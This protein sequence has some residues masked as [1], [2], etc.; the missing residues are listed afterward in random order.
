MTLSDAEGGILIS[1]DVRDLSELDTLVLATH[2]IDGIAGYKLGISLALSCGLTEAVRR[3]RAVCSLPIV[4]D[5]QKGATDIPAMGALF[6]R[7]CASAGVHAA[8]LFPLSGPATERAWIKELRT[9]GVEPV[10]GGLMTHPGFLESE[11]G[12]LL[13]DAPRRMIAAAREEGVTSFVVPGT[14][15]ELASALAAGLG[16]DARFLVPGIG[17]QGGTI[18]ALARQL[19]IR[20]CYPIIGSAVYNSPSPRGSAEKFGESY[21]KALEE[22]QPWVS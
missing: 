17:T 19:P 22:G 18:D 7:V 1:C 3:V 4:Y 6:A 16:Q 12:F 2:D 14:K 8:I 20:Q 11:G 15:L 10:V 9:A 21:R 5:H 13:D